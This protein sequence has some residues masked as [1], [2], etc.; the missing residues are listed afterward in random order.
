MALA[1]LAAT[2]LALRAVA[3]FRYRFD[4]DEPQHLHVVWGWTA[5]LV[6]YRDL[7]DNHAPLFH[8]LSAPLLRALGER[9]DIL[10][11][12]RAPMLALFAIVLGSTFMIARRMYDTRVALWSIVLLS[13]F[14]PFFLKSLE[15][16]TDN[17]WNAFW[18]LALVALTGRASLA[19]RVLLVAFLLGLA[20]SVS[21]KTPLLVI[22]LLAAAAVTIVLTRKPVSAAQLAL[23]TPA[24]LI[25][26]AA[27]P[28]ATAA[29]FYSLGAWRP[30]LFCVIRFNELVEN[31]HRRPTYAHAAYP[32]MLL[33]T[34]Y[35]GQRFAAKRMF[36][37]QSTWRFFF[38]NVTAIFCATLAS[39]WI[40][41]S[42][43]DFLPL[44]PLLA[45]FLAATLV[46]SRFALY[47]LITTSLLFAGFLAYYAAWFVNRTNEHITM[48][49]QVLRLTRPGEPLMDIKGETIY[50]RRPFYFIFEAITRRQIEFGTIAD[51]VPEAV[52]AA[53]C[54]VAQADGPLLPWRTR[55][56]LS[57]NFID[58]GRL[59]A[60]GQW[61]RAD[62]RF[63]IAVPGDYVIVDEDGEAAGRLDETPYVKARYLDAGEHRFIR[64]RKE[65]V[66][67]L[68][69]PAYVRG[70]SPFHLKDR[71][72]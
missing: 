53:R 32:L 22:S 44:L 51:T 55:R 35:L 68:W 72:F 65:R 4:S 41:I 56:F 27:V 14:P 33:V 54:H 62:G 47:G 66:A 59:R 71:E 15:Y 17:L 61:I 16:R 3:Y 34:I 57:A 42:P 43:R 49:N 1:S 21:L 29:Y 23:L 8:F 7:F 24:A 12:M 18:C 10:L 9:A 38:A 26:F 30:M 2:S 64:M 70:F 48:M 58:L 60:S 69:A 39:F 31:T 46:R 25:A 5:G 52:I 63:T 45:I 20:L 50:R 36:D 6:Q 11:Y 37:V 40:L 13:L 67:C 28:A 19:V